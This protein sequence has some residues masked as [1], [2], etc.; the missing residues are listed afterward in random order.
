MNTC[1]TCG[2]WK[3]L[4][5]I[6]GGCD[7]GKIV[8]GEDLYCENKKASSDMLVHQDTYN[9]GSCAYAGKDFGCVHHRPKKGAEDE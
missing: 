8:D 2:Y 6:R 1:E 7:S 5:G 9:Q 4:D 3:S